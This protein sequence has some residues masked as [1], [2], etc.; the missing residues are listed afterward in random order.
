MSRSGPQLNIRNMTAFTKPQIDI[1]LDAA[2]GMPDAYVTS[3]STMDQIHGKVRISAR[4]DTHFDGLE[5]AMLGMLEFATHIFVVCY[6]VRTADLEQ[7]HHLM[8]FLDPTCH[9]TAPC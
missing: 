1:V 2:H 3:F 5:I 8:M 4:H 7:I 6:A 9:A